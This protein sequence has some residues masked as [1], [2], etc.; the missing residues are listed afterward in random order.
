MNLYID[1]TFTVM[2]AIGIEG[3]QSLKADWD[4]L[5]MNNRSYFPFLCHDWYDTWLRNFQAAEL[6]IPVLYREGVIVAI[7]PLM[8][9]TVSKKGLRFKVFEFIGNAYSQA[10]AVLCDATDAAERT[11]FTEK[12]LHYLSQY[13]PNWDYLDLYGLQTENGNLDQIVN[14][15]EGCRLAYSMDRAYENLYQDLPSVSAEEYLCG[16]P[17]IVHR[18]V[19]YNLRRMQR[20]GTLEFRTVADAADMDSV[21]DS[22]YELYA[23]SWKKSEELGPAFHRHLAKFAAVHGWLRLGFMIFNNVPIACQL[24]LV[25][26]GTAY[27]LKVFYDEGCKRYSPGTVLTD[28]MFRMVIDRDQVASVDFLQG[29]EAYKRDW[30]DGVR[31]RKRILVFNNTIKGRAISA[32]LA[33]IRP[34]LTRLCSAEYR[35]VI[36]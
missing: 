21:M 12:L 19:N 31:S 8:K 18:N 2:P 20:E 30:V 15:A 23:R 13:T 16:R 26:Q 7:M 29:D 9:K 17:R 28:Y 24:W 6:Y 33:R 14:A 35:E 3:F 1:H 34:Q 32:Y 27:I 36:A 11:L 10:R 5:A 25:F 4:R 22:Y